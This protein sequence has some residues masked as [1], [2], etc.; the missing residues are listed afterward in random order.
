MPKKV[1]NGWLAPLDENSSFQVDGERPTG[2]FIHGSQWESVFLTYAGNDS[3]AKY[4]FELPREPK[5]L[6]D[7]AAAITRFA[8]DPQYFS[9]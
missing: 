4:L 8:D 3:A 7:F 2:L 6:R 1:R 9:N 5:V